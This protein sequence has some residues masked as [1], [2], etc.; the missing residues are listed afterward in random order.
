MSPAYITT[1]KM[2]YSG[3]VKVTFLAKYIPTFW[4]GDVG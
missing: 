3:S 4:I 1:P 2:D